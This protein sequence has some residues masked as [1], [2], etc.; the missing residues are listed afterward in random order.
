MVE[1]ESTVGGESQSA[2]HAG[3][4]K[5]DQKRRHGGIEECARTCTRRQDKAELGCHEK[6][7]DS[8][9]WAQKL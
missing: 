8:P 9:Q 2:G 4:H 6:V 7:S 1:R 5:C 3:K